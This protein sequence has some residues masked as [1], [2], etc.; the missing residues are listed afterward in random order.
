M[1]NPLLFRPD[2]DVFGGLLA[3]MTPKEAGDLGKSGLE[4]AGGLLDNIAEKAPGSLGRAWQDSSV[5]TMAQ[6]AL[7]KAAFYAGPHLSDRAAAIPAAAA[8]ATE[9]LFGNKDAREASAAFKE[10]K[11]GQGA[12]LLGLG[13]ASA[14]LD[15]P[16]LGTGG[17]VARGLLRGLTKAAHY[18]PDLSMAVAPA[19]ARSLLGK[20]A[21]SA[22]PAALLEQKAAAAASA[23]VKNAAA[24]TD[25]RW[26]P[27]D[28]P[29]FWPWKVDVGTYSVK[30]DLK[31]G[32]KYFPERKASA[33]ETELQKVMAKAEAE[34]KAGKGVEQIFG[35]EDVYRQPL[36]NEALPMELR[37]SEGRGK[38][39]PPHVMANVGPGSG[40]EERLFSS[41]ERGEAAQPW[42]YTGRYLDDLK[43]ALGPEAG[44]ARMDRFGGYMG[45]TTSDAAP[46]FNV[47]MATYQHA[48]ND[49][50][51]A[52]QGG[53]AVQP[54]V[55]PP[56]PYGHSRYSTTHRPALQTLA[57]GEGDL[58]SLLNPK[59]AE[60][61]GSISGRSSGAVM[62]RV[63]MEDVLQAKNAAGKT[64]AAPEPGTYPVYRDWM[65]QQ[66]SSPRF[67]SRFG[68][69]L[70]PDELQAMSWAGHNPD[71]VEQYSKPLV[72]HISD[73]VNVT[74]KVMSAKAGREVSPW[75][76]YYRHITENMPLL[77]VPAAGAGLLSG[78]MQDE[79]R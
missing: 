78:L 67:T 19:A 54:P 4:Y 41:A 53:G 21:P 38:G 71:K 72:G 16:T 63:M 31:K 61:S 3:G 66:A 17:G 22:V 76:V 43:A 64:I 62:D 52:L 30:Q 1:A 27:P 42:Y 37:S 32:G 39:V 5:R 2:E 8:A 23:N 45:A 69:G 79:G 75:E 40:A 70:T 51:R 20:A 56:Y 15:V 9:N 46:P 73:R 6:Q 13:S 18:T 50:Q 36:R 11:V 68:A 49:Q 35:P 25:A 24:A 34:V 74:A 65:Q 7:N 77:A 55:N 12:K 48:L 59:G 60:F 44:Q 26:V 10:G 47:R 57:S 14:L 58:N 28:L 33:G 29:E